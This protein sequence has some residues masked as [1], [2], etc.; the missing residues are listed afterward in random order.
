MPR[1]IKVR[2]CF[3]RRLRRP[4][5]RNDSVH[6]VGKRCTYQANDMR[7]EQNCDTWR[8]PAPLQRNKW[9]Y[10]LLLQYNLS[11]VFS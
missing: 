5:I 3:A 7:E 4:G 9:T 8:M 10:I 2:F 6:S 11:K 1:S